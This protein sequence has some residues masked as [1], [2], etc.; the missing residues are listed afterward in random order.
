M[1]SLSWEKKKILRKS[2]NQRWGEKNHVTTKKKT[3]PTRSHP[4]GLHEMLHLFKSGSHAS[5]S[6][7][8][9][10]PLSA[11]THKRET[12]SSASPARGR[13]ANDHRS[14]KQKNN[15]YRCTRCEGR[16]G[17]GGVGVHSE[18]GK[19]KHCFSWTTRHPPRGRGVYLVHAWPYS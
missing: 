17:G 16:G 12:C 14:E 15:G 2:I 13:A 6:S 18:N 4:Q 5:F 9:Y 3:T 11:V 1:W 7:S 19:K 10:N 8:P